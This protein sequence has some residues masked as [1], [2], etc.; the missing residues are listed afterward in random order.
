MLE[1]QSQ[2]FRFAILIEIQEVTR[3]LSLIVDYIK[4]F[5]LKLKAMFLL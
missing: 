5:I 3:S 2:H 4:I 1:I